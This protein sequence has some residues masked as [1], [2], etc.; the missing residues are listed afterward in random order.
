MLLLPSTE[1]SRPPSGLPSLSATPRTLSS[2][3][4]LSSSAG[5]FSEPSASAAAAAA[6]SESKRLS[7]LS[8]SMPFLRL[9]RTGQSSTS[10]KQRSSEATLPN[11][12]SRSFDLFTPDPSL[13][14]TH[15]L[16]GFSIR[17]D[18]ELA[19]NRLVVRSPCLSLGLGPGIHTQLSLACSNGVRVF[20]VLM[21]SLLCLREV[22]LWC[23]LVSEKQASVSK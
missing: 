10:R 7:L 15:P 8:A 17:Q 22:H 5:S 11:L 6:C 13:L 14:Q 9:Y 3:M 18:F 20:R 1:P 2:A 21:R 12:H 23:H 16:E 4:L 19:M